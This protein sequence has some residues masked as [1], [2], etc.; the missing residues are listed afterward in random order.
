[1][2]FFLN[3]DTIMIINRI[4]WQVKF[5]NSIHAVGII[6]EYNPFHCG[7][8]YHIKKA[9]SLAHTPYCI[10]A[11]SG[12][13][14]Q[15]GA[16]AVF[17]K[18]TRTRMALLSGADL[19]IELPP[20]FATASA[21]DFAACGAALLD[22]LGVVSHLCFGSECGEL[23]PLLEL[24]A[25][26][27]DEPE[28]L[29]S[30]IK[31]YVSLG[32]SYPKARQ[33]ALERCVSLDSNMASHMETLLSSPNNILGI[34]YCKAILRSRSS[35]I[36]LTLSRRGSRYEDEELSHSYSSASAIRKYLL[37]EY[38]SSSDGKISPGPLAGQMPDSCL[39][40]ALAAVPLAV[41]DFSSL[42][43]CRLLELHRQGISFDRFADVSGELAARLE[44]QL[45]NFSSFEDRIAAL[46]TRQYTYTRV[47]RCL[48]HILLHMTAQTYRSRKEEG[49]A[50]YVRILGFRRESAELLS[51]VK[52]A[53]RLPLITKTA[54]GR[55]ILEP[56]TFS[57]FEQD[58]AA[59]HIYQAVLA[60]KSGRPVKNEY[61][62]SIMIV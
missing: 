32:H 46:K 62:Q 20:L 28:E 19:V 35:M 40:L 34:E 13:F 31:Q 45:L 56:R 58:L 52:K 14:V 41:H 53:S 18:Y 25:F 11:I 23:S 8:A 1:M 60:Q 26:M 5:M 47:S 7:H 17:D 36:P 30:L 22:S 12:D 24:A 39:D 43:S 16:P 48:T 38:S 57:W 59:S 42:L 49:Y 51:A 3:Y 50:S 33:I 21:E 6:A 27:C 55:N 10:A 37:S 15:R 4:E 2:A 29:S 9:K 54:H 44:K 61:T